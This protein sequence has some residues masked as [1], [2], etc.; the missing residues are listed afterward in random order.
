MV[1]LS[2]TVKALND[3]LV[4][5]LEEREE[6]AARQDQMLEHISELTDALL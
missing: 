5:L 2:N 3:Y 1:R 6:I 4:E